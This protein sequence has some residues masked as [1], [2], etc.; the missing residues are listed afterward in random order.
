MSRSRTEGMLA[1][2]SGWHW[3]EPQMSAEAMCTEAT[4]GA[5]ITTP[6][7]CEMA[8]GHMEPKIPN[9]RHMPRKWPLAPA[10]W[11]YNFAIRSLSQLCTLRP[12]P[13]VVRKS[14]SS[15]MAPGCPNI[16]NPPRRCHATTACPAVSCPMQWPY[17]TTHASS[18]ILH[19]VHLA[20]DPTDNNDGL[21]AREVDDIPHHLSTMCFTG[22]LESIKASLPEQC[23]LNRVR[24]F[25]WPEIRDIPLRQAER[26]PSRRDKRHV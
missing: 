3:D 26:T 14:S 8:T 25:G 6:S 19:L 5:V 15:M 1:G 12:L 11:A 13:P 16:S 23:G 2:V 20:D 4:I 18:D 17:A 7:K 24:S 10:M 22:L 21:L 9:K